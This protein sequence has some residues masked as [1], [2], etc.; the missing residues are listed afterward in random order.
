MSKEGKP[1]KKQKG[2]QDQRGEKGHISDVVKE[3][4]YLPLKSS[5]KSRRRDKRY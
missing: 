5:V 3:K 2:A 4:K 1:K